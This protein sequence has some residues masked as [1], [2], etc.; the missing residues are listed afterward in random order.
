MRIVGIVGRV[1][2]LANV[3]LANKFTKF[4]ITVEMVQ[5]RW[6]LAGLNVDGPP[7]KSFSERHPGLAYERYSLALGDL[8]V[9]R[10][11]SKMGHDFG[12]NVEGKSRKRHGRV[13]S[14]DESWIYCVC[15]EER[16]VVKEC[17]GRSCEKKEE[18]IAVGRGRAC[19]PSFSINYNH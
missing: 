15:G 2:F 8:L 13:K 11:V 19:Q 12:N 17:E 3:E 10:I 18:A 14:V 5:D 9:G 16:A 7:T 4:W 1:R 6:D